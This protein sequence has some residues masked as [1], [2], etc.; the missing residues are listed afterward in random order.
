MV[1][2]RPRRGAAGRTEGGHG[3]RARR[4]PL[5]AS[6]DPLADP[7][8]H[9]GRP[10]AAAGGLRPRGLRPA[11]R[12]GRPAG[13]RRPREGHAVHRRGPRRRRVRAARRASSAAR[14]CS[15]ARCR[16]SP[17]A[18]RRPLDVPVRRRRTSASP[19]LPAVTSGQVRRLPG[20]AA[21]RGVRATPVGA[22][23]VY[24]PVPRTWTD[25]DGRAARPARRVRRRR[26]RALRRPVGR[27]HLRWPG[28]RSRWRPARSASGRWTC[29]GAPSS[30]TCGARRS[31][32][33]T[34]PRAAAHGR[35]H[36]RS[37]S[38]PTTARP[39][40]RSIEAAL[41]G[42]RPVHDRGA[43]RAAGRRGPLDRLPGPRPG[44]R[45]RRAG[46]DPRHVARRHRRPRRGRGRGCRPSS[47]RPRSPRSPPRSRN[48]TAH[49]R[50][51]R[52]HAARRRRCSAPSPAASPSSTPLDGRCACTWAA[53]SIDVVR[54]VRRGL[55]LPAERHRARA[56]R[57]AA[58]PVRRPHRGAGAA[59]RPARRPPRGSRAWPRWHGSS[60]SGRSPP[61]R[62]GSRGGCSAASSPTGRPTTPSPTRTSSCSRAS[63]RRSR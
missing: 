2:P 35:P 14:R 17:S 37:T 52:H 39:P 16:P 24:D 34:G 36:G 28:W 43:E 58:H 49:R 40:Q 54:P 47:G 4:R 3:A 6:V 23:A 50:A 46:P 30:A 33:S 15:P 20:R 10:P 61:C 45:R 32:A 12:P 38:T 18:R 51:R 22:L 7:H 44:R 21:D 48:A 9:R 56:R 29:A 19:G 55:E 1:R 57:R 41:G 62:C 63:P 26:A 8:A 42:P 5:P 53:G 25:D 11:V 59:A 60:A 13:R 31:S 27:R